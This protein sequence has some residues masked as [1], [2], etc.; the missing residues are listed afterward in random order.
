MDGSLIGPCLLPPRLTGHSYL[1][2]MQEVLGELLEDVSL[3]SRRRLWFQHDGTSSHFA[4]AVPGYVNRYLGQR[5]I[6]RCGPIAWP[7]RSSNLM[8]LD[9]L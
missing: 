4:A 8:P 9:F 3:N 5:W 6:G 7:Q 1:S 2:L